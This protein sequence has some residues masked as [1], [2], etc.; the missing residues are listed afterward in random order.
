[1]NDTIICGVDGSPASDAAV[2]V[3]AEIAQRIEG[4]LVLV[5]VV[6]RL[7]VPYAAAAPMGG[8]APDPISITRSKDAAAT[9]LEEAA[10][11]I[12]LDD[13]ETRVVIGLPSERLAEVADEEGADLIVVG[14][15]GRGSFKAAFLGSVS[16]SLMGVSRCPVVVVPPG[17]VRSIS[18]RA[19]SHN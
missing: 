5:N 17:A 3:A 16:T 10:A 1:M 9:L 8:V 4:R 19:A 12:G 15:R 6:G 7:A 14:S 18:E 11:G 2:Q 13:V